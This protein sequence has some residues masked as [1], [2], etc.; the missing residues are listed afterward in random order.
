MAK[1]LL[2]DIFSYSCMNCLRSLKYIKKIDKK[3]K[4]YGLKTIIIHPPEWNFEKQSS[5]ILEAAIKYKIK[6]PIII[7]KDEWIIKKLNVDFWPTQILIKEN[8]ILYRHIGEGNYQGLEKSIM[9]NLS[10]K[11]KKEFAHEPRYSKFPTIYCG[12]KKKGKIRNLNNKLKFGVIYIDNNWI[13]KNEFIQSLNNNAKLSIKTKGK[14]IN[15]IAESLSGNPVKT[16]IKINNK[17]SKTISI[18]K[19][20]LYSII[21]LNNNKENILNIIT[22]KNIAIY[23]FSFQ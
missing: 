5:N 12:K 23:S 19:P 6:I 9:K 8:K 21:K 11:S 3:Y 15:F 7:D 10:V 2:L 1:L 13:Q 18:N 4:K 22:N 17:K 20:Q 14:K 16:F